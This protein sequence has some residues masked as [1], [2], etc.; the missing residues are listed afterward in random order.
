MAEL[1]F[2]DVKTLRTVSPSFGTVLGDIES[3]MPAGHP[4]SDTDKIT[5]AHETTHGINANVRNSNLVSGKVFNAFYVLE[6][7]AL[8]LE[9]PKLKIQDAAPNVPSSL[10]GDIYKLYMVDQATNA[11]ESLVNACCNMCSLAYANDAEATGWNDRPLYLFDEW[12][13]YQNGSAARNDLKIADRAETVAFMW[14]MAVYSSYM[15]MLDDNEERTTA[16]TWML[17]RSSIIYYSSSSTSK[18]DAYLA[19]IK[20]ENNLI[21]FWKK[22]GFEFLQNI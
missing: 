21:D 18:A 14:E 3:K 19:K 2:V 8:L 11:I 9:E 16:L 4:Y 7:K 6:G 12:S 15:L 10:R 20:S 1:K 13:A 22:S 5:W 17:N